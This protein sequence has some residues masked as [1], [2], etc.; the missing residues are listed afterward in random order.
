M[1]FTQF[2]QKFRLLRFQKYVYSDAKKCLKTAASPW[3]PKIFPKKIACGGLVY[4]DPFTQ[5]PFTYYFEIGDG[6]ARALARHKPMY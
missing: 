1:P 5:T 3:N 2:A 4:S 6:E